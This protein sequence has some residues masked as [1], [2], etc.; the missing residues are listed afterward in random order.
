M[1]G[2]VR[3]THGLLGLQ[4]RRFHSWVSYHDL[5]GLDLLVFGP[6]FR[7]L[8]HD[9]LSAYRV[10][11]LTGTGDLEARRG[12]LAFGNLLS[13]THNGWYGLRP[14]E[15]EIGRTSRQGKYEHRC[16]QNED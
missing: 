12:N 8:P 10:W 2:P 3:L 11:I 7:L 4:K 1:Q 16:C 15:K 13:Q 5:D 6:R 14:E 9:F